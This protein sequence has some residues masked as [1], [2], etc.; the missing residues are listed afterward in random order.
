MGCFYTKACRM[1]GANGTYL[2]ER[3]KVQALENFHL[4]NHIL[5][6]YVY[7]HIHIHTA[8]VEILLLAESDRHKS[9]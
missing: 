3:S 6:L 5:F 1:S 9:F 4:V 2:Y 7:T 8:G